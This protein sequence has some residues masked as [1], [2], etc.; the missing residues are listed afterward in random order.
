MQ[1]PWEAMLTFS[2]GA[3]PKGARQNLR[4]QGYPWESCASL[5]CGLTVALQSSSCHRRSEARR[6]VSAGRPAGPL[7]AARVGR[8]PSTDLQLQ[9]IRIYDVLVSGMLTPCLSTTFLSLPMLSRLQKF[10]QIPHD[11]EK[12]IT[13]GHW[14]ARF[15][16]IR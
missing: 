15:S 4:M 2:E 1:G 3:K 16:A 7:G 12:R 9:R 8:S 5:L 6:A 11:V 10:I 13:F 14:V